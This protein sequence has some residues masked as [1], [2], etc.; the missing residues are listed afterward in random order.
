MKEIKDD[1][2]VTQKN[3]ADISIERRPKI[4]AEGNATPFILSQF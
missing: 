4:R 3:P 1:A 2:K